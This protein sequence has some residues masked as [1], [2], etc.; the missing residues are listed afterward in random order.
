MSRDACRRYN[1][2]HCRN[3]R[4]TCCRRHCCRNIRPCMTMRMNLWWPNRYNLHWP[5]RWYSCCGHSQ[6]RDCSH[7]K[8]RDSNTPP[9]MPRNPTRS[10]NTRRY[11]CNCG[12][13]RCLSMW[14]MNTSRNCNYHTCNRH[15]CPTQYRPT[16]HSCRPPRPCGNMSAIS[17]GT[18]CA[19]HCAFDFACTNRC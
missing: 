13:H 14:C 6:T 5:G 17:H 15:S 4:T 1:N 3:R 12:R 18:N 2:S 19:I 16:H 10:N 7:L 9:Y 8:I 11:S